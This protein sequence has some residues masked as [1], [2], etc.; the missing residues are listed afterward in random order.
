[1]GCWG[2]QILLETNKPPGPKPNSLL[3]ATDHHFCQ[4][5]LACSRYLLILNNIIPSDDGAL[6]VILKMRK[7]YVL[8]YGDVVGPVAVSI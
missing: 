1:M 3:Y 2:L 4:L 8:N 6:D 5:N 7:L